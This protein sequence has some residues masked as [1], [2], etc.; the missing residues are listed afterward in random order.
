MAKAEAF[1]AAVA[2]TEPVAAD[3]NGSVE[4]LLA[5]L[6]PDL[7][8]DAAG[9]F[10]GSDYR[11][12][13]ACIGASIPYVDLADA[14]A[15]VAGIGALQAEAVAA[16]VPVIAGASSVPALSG[17]AARCLAAGL[18]RIC[19]VEIAI[20]AAKR[21]TLGASVVAAILSYAGQPIRLWR[22]RRWECSFGWQELQRSD[23]P[24]TGDTGLK[25]RWLALADVPD[26]QLL[27]LALPGHPSVVFRAG[28]ESASQTI[29]LWLLTWLV[30]WF[31]VSIGRLA[32]VLSWMQRLMQ[33]S[34]RDTSAMDVHL[35]GEAS[36]R[37]F[38]RRW[39]LVAWNGDGVEIPTLATV[40]VAED[41]LA[42]R[43]IPGACAAD[44]LLTLAAF[45]PLFSTLSIR[46][47]TQER[48]LSPPLYAR[49]L[50]QS[51]A[52]LPAAV[53][54]MH[55]LCGD[56]GASG[57]AQVVRGRGIWARLFGS[58]IGFPPAGSHPL[59]VSFFERDGVERWTR[60]FGNRSFSSQLS[61][62]AGRLVERFGPLRF[63]FEL[64][65]D[66]YGLAMH[67]CQWSVFG[68][69]LPLA[70]APRTCAR[71]WEEDGRFRFDVPILLPLIGL[72]VRYTGWLQ[73]DEAEVRRA[74]D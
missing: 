37:F 42:G 61:E 36:G 53:R 33:T 55:W 3:R 8:I 49:V 22:G 21:A 28:N 57:E 17:A 9:P 47:E 74:S 12:P 70:L 1:C 54:K 69:P 30:R 23:F 56:G 25:K 59:H 73:R 16:G 24:L 48:P 64:P 45:E 41:I 40:L 20:S 13:R 6:A 35:R 2:R 10:Q 7:V 67:I 32:P 29:G 34:S 46:H 15:F 19:S 65:S 60:H 18:D 63:V 50:G 38:A 14:R 72:V 4:T 43:I 39:T 62:E 51:F 58:L 71:E 11:L 27:P 31:G 5:R 52:V 26:L 44:K 66:E 68:V